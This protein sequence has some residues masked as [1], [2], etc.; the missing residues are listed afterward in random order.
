MKLFKKPFFKS[1][2]KKFKGLRLKS[3]I[4]STVD[5]LSFDES[6]PSEKGVVVVRPSPVK[7]ILHR[8]PT[9]V[10]F[11][12]PAVDPGPGHPS[13]R[14]ERTVS[15]MV[16]AEPRVRI[17]APILRSDSECSEV[18]VLKKDMKTGELAFGALLAPDLF[19]F[20]RISTE[21]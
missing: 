20:P 4:P 13:L 11:K 9:E 1:F 2:N 7:S 21:A 12:D 3:C 16:G 17:P 19:S 10:R 14:L 15:R 5:Q 8:S 6:T 18:M